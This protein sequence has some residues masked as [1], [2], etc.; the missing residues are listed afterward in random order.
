MGGRGSGESKAAWDQE[1]ASPPRRGDVKVTQVEM[2]QRQCKRT[3]N[4]IENMTSPESSPPPTP[5]PEHCNVDKAEENDLKNRL[6]KM[7]EEAFEEKMKNTFKEIEEM[8]NKKLEDIKE[9]NL[10]GKEMKKEF[11]E[12]NKTWKK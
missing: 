2:G 7:L 11:E 10:K 6:M 3:Y 4:N 1:D 8:T 12:K 5:R 9:K